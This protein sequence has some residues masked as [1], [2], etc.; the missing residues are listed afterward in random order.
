MS[1]VGSTHHDKRPA[2][3]LG[4]RPTLFAPA[5]PQ[6]TINTSAQQNPRTIY[7]SQLHTKTRIQIQQVHNNQSRTVDTLPI[8]VWSNEFSRLGGYVSV[9]QILEKGTL[10]RMHKDIPARERNW[11]P[12]AQPVSACEQ[13]TDAIR[14]NN[15][16]KKPKKDAHQT[17]RPLAGKHDGLGKA[18][19]HAYEQKA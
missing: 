8:G 13:Q 12:L 2:H 16:P 4:S 5:N 1:R 10:T 15:R 3:L 17:V 11:G 9:L 19:P 18:H 14:R 7:R 6:N